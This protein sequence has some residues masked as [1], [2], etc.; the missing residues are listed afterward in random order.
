MPLLSCYQYTAFSSLSVI[1]KWALLPSFL[2]SSYFLGYYCCALTPSFSSLQ[3]SLHIAGK[4]PSLQHRSEYVATLPQNHSRFP[5]PIGQ[6]SNSLPWH[7]FRQVGP[8]P[9]CPLSSLVIPPTLH[10]SRFSIK[11]PSSFIS[12]CF[13]SCSYLFLR[14][15]SL[16]AQSYPSLCRNLLMLP[17]RVVFWSSSPLHMSAAQ[18]MCDNEITEDRDCDVLN[19]VSLCIAHPCTAHSKGSV[20]PAG[21]LRSLSILPLAFR[22]KH[23]ISQK[24]PLAHSFLHRIQHDC[25]Q[26]SDCSYK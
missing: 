6:H 16:L 23:K 15:P 1:H 24:L 26:F 25:S 8:P 9:T 14:N 20:I 10:T 19:F 2:P 11:A 4:D 18:W 22:S 3:V 12:L 5:Y 17:R 21:R 7:S 13:C